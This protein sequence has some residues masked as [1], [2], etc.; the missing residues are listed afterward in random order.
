MKYFNI[1][2]CEV[3]ALPFDKELRGENKSKIL[4]Q[5]V[6]YKLPKDANMDE[7]TYKAIHEKFE[8]YGKIKSTKISLN[9][10][11]SKRG[12]AFVCFENLEDTQKCVDDLKDS[13]EIF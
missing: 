5:N 8:K 11:H 2:G 13:G 1:D 9:S 6:F 10:D 3:R 7:L 4:N 12:F